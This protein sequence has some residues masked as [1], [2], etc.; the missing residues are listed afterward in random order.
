MN[1]HEEQLE[2]MSIGSHL[3]VLRQ[4]IIRILL[5]VAVLAVIIFC[6]KE[7]TFRLLLA[8]KESDFVTFRIIEQLSAWMA[9]WAGGEGFH[10]EPYDIQLISTELSAQFMM[11]LS[12]SFALAGLLA[13]PY[14]LYEL[15]GYI[16][17]ALYAHERRYTLALGISCYL[18]FALGVLMTYYILAPIS[19]RFLGTYQVD[20]S[21]QNTITLDSYISTFTSLTFAMGLVFQLPVLS[22]ILAKMGWLKAR[23]ME[24][25]RRHALVLIMIV[26]AIIT[27]PDVFT[28]I[29][30][31]GPLYMLYEVCIVIVRRSEK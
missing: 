27:P 28:L 26:A 2:T 5:V 21:V 8:P 22:W 15:L 19:F 13:S 14:I 4:M 1:N 16:T 20:A 30:V 12:S 23:Y 24:R 6:F 29:L 25:Y 31:T 7:E 18:L 3:E 11:H 10:F 17:P 9:G